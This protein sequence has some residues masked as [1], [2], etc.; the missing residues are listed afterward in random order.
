MEVA[1]VGA[2]VCFCIIHVSGWFLDVEDQGEWAGAGLVGGWRVTEPRR[3]PGDL[4]FHWGAW[5]MGTQS[6]GRRN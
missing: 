2:S 3:D 4:L 5:G 1:S 6:Q